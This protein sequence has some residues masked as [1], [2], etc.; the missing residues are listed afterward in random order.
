MQRRAEVVEIV[1]RDRAACRAR[2]IDQRVGEIVDAM[3]DDTFDM[4]DAHKYEQLRSTVAAVYNDIE[5]RRGDARPGNTDRG[6]K[7]GST[8]ASF[9]PRRAGEQHGRR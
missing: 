4:L 5:R 6:N 9:P 2:A 1:R 7:F 8:L 3:D